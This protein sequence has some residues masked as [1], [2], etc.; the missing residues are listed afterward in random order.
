M[1]MYLKD[2]VYEAAKK[3]IEWLYDEFDNIIVSISGGKDS[4]A[5]LE[6]TLEVARERG[7]LPVKVCFIDQ[8]D[9]WSYTIDYI[10]YIKSRPEF[11]LYW[12]QVPVL[13][14]S[15]ANHKDQYMCSWDPERKD[16][17]MRQLEPDS[18][19]GDIPQIHKYDDEF[20]G[21]LDV[22]PAMIFNY[23]KYANIGGVR[24][25]ESLARFAAT[26][27]YRCYKDATWGKIG[28]WGYS[29]YPLY[30][31]KKEDV[32]TYIAKNK[33]RYNKIYDLYF[34]YG[35]PEHQMRV[36]SLHHETAYRSMFM[37]QELDRKTYDTMCDRLDGVSTFS[38]LQE[39]VTPGGLPEM[40][41]SW[42]EYRDYLLVHLIRP[43]LQE[44]FIN[45]WKNQEGDDWYQEHVVEVL[46]NDTVGTKNHNYAIKLRME[47]K[48]NNG[49]MNFEERFGKYDEQSGTAKSTE[50][51]A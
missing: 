12:F 46:V 42:K 5:V 21:I 37:L 10:R 7:R 49:K 28:K 35:V 4:T 47:Q 30:D 23:E 31:W 50:G 11:E 25:E 17:W 3:R 51:N 33:L 45:R 26:T 6:M 34:N 44:I 48:I 9:E 24:A 14:T 40:F 8:E 41:G 36:S 18:I 38:Q 19:Q 13:E 43:D 27:A 15:S 1:K 29:F 39:Q 22:G 20:K 32:W 2:N 16:K